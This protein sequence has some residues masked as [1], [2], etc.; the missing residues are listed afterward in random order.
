M[1]IYISQESYSCIIVPIINYIGNYF[2]IMDHLQYA[3]IYHVVPSLA[4]MRKVIMDTFEQ[5]QT[6]NISVVYTELLYKII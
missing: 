3:L 4:F 1:R 5:I 6:V 2:V